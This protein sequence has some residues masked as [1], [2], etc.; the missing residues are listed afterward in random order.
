MYPL[1]REGITGKEDDNLQ[2]GIEGLIKTEGREP[3]VTLRLDFEFG[4]NSGFAESDAFI[5]EKERDRH[6]QILKEE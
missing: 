3:Y 1:S 2:G 4:F 6:L 5:F